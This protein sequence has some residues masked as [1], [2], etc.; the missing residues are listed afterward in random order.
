VH[1]NNSAK[2]QGTLYVVGTPI[3]NL[4]DITLRAVE[5][6]RSVE[7]VAAE[8]TRVSRKLISALGIKKKL[9]SHHMHNEKQS[10]NKIVSMLEKGLCVALVCDSGTPCVSDPGVALI[11]RSRM[12]GIEV[13]T[14]PGPSALT[15]ALSVCGMSLSSV[16]FYGF[17]PQK[18]TL[19]S[20]ILTKAAERDGLQVFYESP[21][22]LRKTLKDFSSSFGL[23]RS[24]TICKELTKIHEK[25]KKFTISALIK[26]IDV[27]DFD[28]RGEFVL[29]LEGVDDV[30]PKLPLDR[31][32]PI[33]KKLFKKMSL[34]EAVTLVAEL[35]GESRKKL[36][37]VALRVKEIVV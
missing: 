4:K 33:F 27:E 10:T 5:T 2:N 23:K 20:A 1:N 15:A 32:E 11:E 22:R 17:L 9:I 19:R 35:S 7:V 3:G 8:D 26:S 31:F 13:L 6:L 28:I 36:Y 18:Q 37:S 30:S 29:I 34:K 16:H 12:L 21:H 25:T 14:V 24:I